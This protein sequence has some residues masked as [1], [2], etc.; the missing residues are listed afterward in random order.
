MRGGEKER[1]RG[2]TRAVQFDRRQTELFS[3]DRV[4]DF[5]CVF[6]L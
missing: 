1:E 2:L 6:K 3:N 5:C 4:L